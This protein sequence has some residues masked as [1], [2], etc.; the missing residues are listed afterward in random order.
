MLPEYIMR[1]VYSLKQPFTGKELLTGVFL[2]VLSICSPYAAAQ[3]LPPPTTPDPTED[4]LY[5]PPADTLNISAFIVANDPELDTIAQIA[6]QSSVNVAD[7]ND[8][9]WMYGAYQSPVTGKVKL[10]VITTDD[11]LNLPQELLIV[12]EF[13]NVAP[14]EMDGRRIGYNRSFGGSRTGFYRDFEDTEDNR[15]FGPEQIAGRYAD[16]TYLTGIAGDYTGTNSWIN[17]GRTD[18]FSIADSR[19]AYVFNLPLI[20][21]IDKALYFAPESFYRGF[22]KNTLDGKSQPIAF[23]YAQFYN[24]YSEVNDV[25]ADGT[26]VGGSMGRQTGD[27]YNMYPFVYSYQEDIGRYAIGYILNGETGYATGVNAY[28]D[29]M[30]RFRPPGSATSVEQAFYLKAGCQNPVTEDFIFDIILPNR[31]ILTND[32]NE[33]SMVIGSYLINGEDGA[34]GVENRPY[35]YQNCDCD[36]GDF[37]NLNAMFKAQYPAVPWTLR[38]GNGI[39]NKNFAVGKGINAQ[40]QWINWRVRVPDCFLCINKEF[41]T[42]YM[43]KPFKIGNEAF[44]STEYT[45]EIRITDE[46]DPSVEMEVYKEEQ[47]DSLITKNQYFFKQDHKY[48]VEI[49]FLCGGVEKTR[50]LE[51]TAFMAHIPRPIPDNIAAYNDLPA[52]QVGDF[53]IPGPETVFDARDICPEE[54]FDLLIIQQ[55]RAYSSFMVDKEEGPDGEESI[56]PFFV[57]NEYPLFKEEPEVFSDIIVRELELW[58]KR[59]PDSL[60]RYHVMSDM[61]LMD[62]TYF[63]TYISRYSAVWLNFEGMNEFGYERYLE[64]REEWME[65][66]SKHIVIATAGGFYQNHVQW[67]L[68][69][70]DDFLLPGE[71][72]Y[73]RERGRLY[74]ALLPDR[75]SQILMDSL[76]VHDATG[77]EQEYIFPLLSY[78]KELEEREGLELEE[79]KDTLFYQTEQFYKFI[80]TAA[81][82]AKTNYAE[83]FR[84]SSLYING[85]EEYHELTEYGLGRTKGLQELYEFEAGKQYEVLALDTGGVGETAQPTYGR[86][87]G[88]DGHT[89]LALNGLVWGTANNLLFHPTSEYAHAQMLSNI[90]RKVA[91]MTDTNFIVSPQRQF[92]LHAN[93]DPCLR[94]SLPPD[95]DKQVE[96]FIKNEDDED[97]VQIDDPQNFAFDP[98]HDWGLVQF[99]AKYDGRADTVWGNVANWGLY[100]IDGSG[101]KYLFDSDEPDKEMGGVQTDSGKVLIIMHGWQMSSVYNRSHTIAA[102]DSLMDD[103]SLS[104]NDLL[105]KRWYDS[106]YTVVEL[107]WVQIADMHNVQDLEKRLWEPEPDEDGR[108]RIPWKH[109]VDGMAQFLSL[110]GVTEWSD[111]VSIDTKIPIYF[112]DEI[113][114]F[115]REKFGNKPIKEFR[116]L[117]HSLGAGISAEI[118]QTL[119][120]E[121]GTLSLPMLQTECVEKRLEMADPYWGAGYNADNAERVKYLAETWN[122]A[123]TSYVTTG[124]R[125]ISNVVSNTCI[126]LF[127]SEASSFTECAQSV[128]E[129]V[130]EQSF[131]RFSRKRVGKMPHTRLFKLFKVAQIVIKIVQTAIRINEVWGNIVANELFLDYVTDVRLDLRWFGEIIPGLRNPLRQHGAAW[132]HVLYNINQPDPA[133]LYPGG[134]GG[135]DLLAEFPGFNPATCSGL[136]R[137]FAGI[138]EITQNP[139]QGRYTIS[140]EDDTLRFDKLS[141]YEKFYDEQWEGYVCAEPDVFVIE[142]DDILNDPTP[143]EV[144]INEPFA[145]SVNS[146]KYSPNSVFITYGKPDKMDS[147]QIRWFDVEDKE[148]FWFDFEY[149]DG[150]S[151]ENPDS[152]YLPYGRWVIRAEYNCEAE[153]VVGEQVFQIEALDYGLYFKD[154]KGQLEKY[155][156]GEENKNFTEGNNTVIYVHGYQG[157]SVEERY[158]DDLIYADKDLAANF[159][160]L[161]WNVGIFNWQQFADEESMA[162]AE[163]KIYDTYP[164]GIPY[165]SWVENEVTTPNPALGPIQNKTVANLL[166]DALD[167]TMKGFSDWKEQELRLVGHNIG[168]QIIA[169]AADE[170]GGQNPSRITFLEPVWT[171]GREQDLLTFVERLYGYEDLENDA[172]DPENTSYS[173][174]EWYTATD[175]DTIGDPSDPNA[176]KTFPNRDLK[177]LAAMHRVLSDFMGG[178]LNKSGAIVSLSAFMGEE[179]LYD[180]EAQ[181]YST[182]PWYFDSYGN[183]IPDEYLHNALIESTIGYENLWLGDPDEPGYPYY[184]LEQYEGKYYEKEENIGLSAN[185][186]TDEVKDKAGIESGQLKGEAT[187]STEDDVHEVLHWNVPETAWEELINDNE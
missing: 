143:L 114:E 177:A 79:A 183:K 135:K 49:D 65:F 76:L 40:G 141:E 145:F 118:M 63:F 158:F 161:G 87:S 86:F 27:V 28:E 58:N 32:I 34:S 62:S 52:E 120:T 71:Q 148:R 43:L 152:L 53:E 115:M 1:R 142:M 33:N 72:L 89:I 92:V 176:G 23:P 172:F 119:L 83:L 112:T 66:A 35:I 163:S 103:A 104:G 150:W 81:P 108:I 125:D 88:S 5:V 11:S 131:K 31:F 44:N 185:T 90:V 140:T 6:G 14:V 16:F 174:F 19:P 169:S 69:L 12:G 85:E 111:D 175:Y 24:R 29:V 54:G 78:M 22:I 46:T 93:D 25:T 3:E 127:G 60:I 117:G 94:T 75:K 184:V 20:G 97:F 132:A 4:S 37:F 179:Y 159:T 99:I 73:E 61:N 138:R 122:V 39:N 102:S 147:T 123:T 38:L 84:A 100:T 26:A 51:V 187:L 168:A 96:W 153:G 164:E 149:F 173:A 144:V 98:A 70:Y 121:N 47:L 156:S 8:E 178:E 154:E 57:Q 106:G 45:S 136:V 48:L 128:L 137:R 13:D 42:W 101:N 7:I 134:E 165:R 109:H 157:G 56:L 67:G 113:R 166:A 77:T 160:G 82:V 186:C 180:D 68:T 133:M 64:H 116:M 151:L 167:L 130:M 15:G 171:S 17:P 110:P 10:F 18:Y 95:Q 41:Y 181:Y 36:Q 139:D 2:L 55:N 30:G 9:G 162:S 182:I 170:F 59:H 21:T 126:F 91:H 105:I 107:N 50:E 129:T 74:D 80:G 124:F 155:V 146:S